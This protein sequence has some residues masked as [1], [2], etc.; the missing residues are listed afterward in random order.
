[1]FNDEKAMIRVD[2]SEY[3]EKHSVSKLVG[4]P[5]GYVGYDES[6]QLTEAVRHR[7]YSV[8]LFDEVEKAHPEIFNL[9]LQVLDEGRLKD[10]KGRYVN[11]KKLYHCA[12][13]KHRFSVYKQNGI[14]WILFQG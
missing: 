13:I 8:I 6:G 1:M 7:P 5:P 3:M 11:F 14:N 12:Y 4:S 2:M 9:L 10:S